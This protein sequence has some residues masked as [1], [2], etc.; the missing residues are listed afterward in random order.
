MRIIFGRVTPYLRADMDRH[1]ITPV[2]GAEN[3]HAQLHTAM[4]ATRHV[5]NTHAPRPF[6][7]P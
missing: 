5:V 6:T 4:A 1:R 2:I 3:I 7:H